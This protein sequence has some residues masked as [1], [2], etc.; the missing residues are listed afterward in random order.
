MLKHHQ[1]VAPKNSAAEHNLGCNLSSY[2]QSYKWCLR[3]PLKDPLRTISLTWQKE[4]YKSRGLFS[5]KLTAN[6]TFSIHCRSSH[7]HTAGHQLYLEEPYCKMERTSAGRAWEDNSDGKFRAVSSAVGQNHHH[8]PFLNLM[9]ERE[10]NDWIKRT[11]L[12]HKLS[13]SIK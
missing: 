3:K 7:W 5:K 12:L 4:G 13:F 8:L 2:I 11:L 10:Q 6:N 9:N 1:K